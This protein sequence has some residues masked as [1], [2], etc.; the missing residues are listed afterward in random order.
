MYSFPQRSEEMA[1]KRSGDAESGGSWMDTYGDMVTLLLCFF[2]LLFAMSS[3]DQSKFQYIAQALSSMGKVVNTVVAENV[4]VED[5]SGNLIEDAELNAGGGELPE[6]FDEL[7]TFLVAY[8][9]ENGLQ[10]SVEVEKG[11][12]G[13]TLRFRDNIFFDP[14][15]AVLRESGRELISNLAPAFSSVDS[16]ILGIKVSGHTAKVPESP[17]DEWELSSD[18]ANNVLRYMMELDF[19]SVDKLSSSGY[20][21]YR[22]VDTNDTEDGRRNNRRVEI[23]IA[24]SDVDYSNPSVVQEFLDMEYGRD[25]VDAVPVD[26]L[27]N[28]I[29]T[30]NEVKQTETETAV[31]ETTAESGMQPETL[32][33]TTSASE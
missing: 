1:K 22:P 9:E 18:R 15:S 3:M 14:D 16:Y 32:P 2:V 23:T 28:V 8:V 7:Y 30:G 24:R 29:Y 5:P 31:S 33:E 17:V 4:E 20:G 13:I 10:A 19:C 11:A 27:G 12:A 26:S 21:G 6:S 25:K